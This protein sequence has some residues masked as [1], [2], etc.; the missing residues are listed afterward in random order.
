MRIIK[1][2]VWVAGLFFLCGT[3][4]VWG[5][6]GEAVLVVLHTND[7]HSQIEPLN[8]KE[9]QSVGG[10]L[11]RKTVIDACR[12]Q[13]PD[14][15]L[16]LDAGDF[17]QGTPYFNYFKGYAEVKFMNMLGYDAVT[18]GN[19][20]FDNGCKALAKRLKK[21][22]FEIVC[23]NY[24]FHH[25]ELQKLVKPYTILYR[26]NLKIGIFGLTVNLEGLVNPDV[27]KEV[28]YKDPV[29]VAYEMTALL[30]NREKCDMIICLSHLGY[31]AKSEFPI[32]DSLL[33][34]YVKDIDIIIGG[35]THLEK[36]TE[37]NG[38]KILQLV[39]K[40]GFIGKLFIYKKEEHD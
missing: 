5:Q 18:L 11:R 27:E 29:V 28:T 8:N 36:N 14:K 25:K 39:N 13:Y 17:S 16:L 34:Q 24:E 3:M 31:N 6:N 21:A 35:H 22:D 38:V 40:G 4:Y 32:Y 37:V 33:A 26:N 7:T 10:V 30:K 19:H 15:L 12:Q 20:E 9:G 2:I 23:A 1:K